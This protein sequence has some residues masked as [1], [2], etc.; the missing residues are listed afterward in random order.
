MGY[1]V[2][3]WD[4]D[5]DAP[6]HRIA[7]HSFSASFADH[8]TR[9]RFVDR[10]QA[11]TLEWENI[12]ADLCEWLEQHRPLR[13]SSTV[14]RIVQDRLTQ[15]QFLASCSLPV[16]DFA[17]V[18]S[19]HQLH[20]VISRLGLPLICKTARSGYD[21][22][23]QWLVQQPSDI[24]QFEWH[25]TSPS[26][27][28]RWIAEQFITFVRELSVLV[29]R[30]VSGDIRV[31]PVVENRHE[32]G[33]LRDSRVPAS[34]SS[35]EA[36]AASELSVRAVTAL[37]GVGVFCVELFQAQ[38]G[39]LLINEI[40]PRPHNSGHYTLDA[41]TVSQFEQQV[42]VTCGL[43]LGEVRLLSSAVMVNL[44]GDEVTAVMSG[45]GRREPFSIPGASVHFYGKRVIRPGRKMGHVTFTAPE[46][47]TAVARAQQFLSRVL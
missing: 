3:V 40:A 17:E 28:I 37:Q 18:Q 41:C 5:V 10:V 44:L 7:D 23:G 11:I 39:P 42:R 25:L 12:P 15:K 22:K 26:S 47:G 24:E 30:S 43:P 29:V 34:I 45:G 36:T 4:P 32:Q 2:V 21:G 6:A 8:E 46:I 13:P 27:G 14:L 31:Y 35:R 16:P 38:D 1:R 9:E 19:G 20:Q 33:I